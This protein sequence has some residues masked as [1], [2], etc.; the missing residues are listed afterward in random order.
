MVMMLMEVEDQPG[1][2]PAVFPPPIS[3]SL[4]YF[5][6]SI[7][8]GRL[9]VISLMGSYLWMILGQDG[10]VGIET[11]VKGAM[12]RPLAPMARPKGL[13]M[14]WGPPGASLASSGISS[15]HPLA[16][17]EKNDVVKFLGPFDVRKVPQTKKYSK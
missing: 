17:P 10:G 4:L 15:S 3:V 1:A 11:E 5:V 16:F 9:F 2:T 7:F 6:Y 8:R 14:P 13:A 12:R